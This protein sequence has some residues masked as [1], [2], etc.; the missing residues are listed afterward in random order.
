MDH[1]WGY[2]RKNAYR[3]SPKP[4]TPTTGYFN[5]YPDMIPPRVRAYRGGK[6][7]KSLAA[8]AVEAFAMKVEGGLSPAEKKNL[9]KKLKA[10]KKGKAKVVMT[11]EKKRLLADFRAAKKAGRNVRIVQGVLTYLD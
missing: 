3:K 1:G 6:K 8:G 4:Y 5:T 9:T 2:Y 10:V 7:K 11:P